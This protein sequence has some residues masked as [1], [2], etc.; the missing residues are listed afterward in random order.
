M[1]S[2]IVENTTRRTFLAA[3][4][5]APAIVRAQKNSGNSLPVV[6]AGHT[7]YEVIHDWGELPSDIKWGNT[8]AVVE[9]SHGM[10]YIHHTVHADS[11]SPDSV[12]VFDEKGKF[13]RSFGAMFRGGAHGMHYSKEGGNEYLYFCDEKHGIVTKR[14]MKGEEVWTL[15]YPHDSKPYQTR[16]NYRPTN[17]AVASNGDFWVGDGYGSY[18]MMHYTQRGSYPQLVSTFGGRPDQPVGGQP[19]QSDSA[20]P[21]IDQMNNPHGNWIDMRNPSRPILMVA[22]RGNHRIVRYGLDDKPIDA[23]E[24]TL[25]PCHFHFYKDVMVV[26]DLRCRVSLF[27]KNNKL[28]A[29]LCD[30]GY[31]TDVSKIRVSQDRSTF[32]PGKFITPHGAAFDHDG[33]IFVTEWVEIGRVT[34]L[35]RIA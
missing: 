11:K 21:P 9:D 31:G 2:R 24:G 15:G 20:P 28:I 27:D 17:I 14:S 6:R 29:H 3:T 18:F 10:I 8:H 4:I 22:D 1:T 5:A 33:N 23:I 7:E 25:M 35:R 19:S 16:R 13:V 30:G 26:P 12:V 34:K 32:E